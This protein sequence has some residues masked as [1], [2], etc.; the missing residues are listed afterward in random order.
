MTKR[1]P[2]APRRSSKVHDDDAFVAGVLEASN[3][4]RDNR[5]KLVTGGIALAVVVVVGWYFV[6]TN[7]NRSRRA[8]VELEQVTAVANS[9]DPEQAKAELSAYVEQFGATPYGDEARLTLAVLYLETDL[10]GQ[11]LNTIRSAN[12]GPGDPL[13]PQF[14]ALEAKA[15]ETRGD[16]EAAEEV[17][18]RLANLANHEFQRRTAL[19]DAAR[20]RAERGE[21]A[22]A[23]EIWE[24]L[25]AELAP[26]D[27]RQG[28]Y[29]MRAAEMRQRQ[30]AG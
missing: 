17:Y 8:L 13:G 14:L 9:A 27:T 20:I 22:L 23:A 15:L 5:Q 3:W 6:A 4:A 24:E 10:P 1:R 21:Y 28:V 29:L 11:A 19:E 7:V 18:L 26:S 2:N 12:S 25:A 30:R 16:L